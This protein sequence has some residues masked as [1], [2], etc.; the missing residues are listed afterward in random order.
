MTTI[1]NPSP[2]PTPTQISTE[3]KWEHVDWLVVNEGEAQQLLKALCYSSSLEKSQSQSPSDT[4]DAAL[5]SSLLLSQLA[6]QTS[7]K[8]V[9]IVCTLGAAGVVA[10][11]L[12]VTG[13]QVIYEPGIPA[14]NVVDTTGAG[15]CWTGYL[16]VGLMAIKP[17]TTLDKGHVHMLLRRC[18]QVPAV[19]HSS[20]ALFYSAFFRFFPLSFSLGT[21]NNVRLRRSSCL[22]GCSNVCGKARGDGKYSAMGRG[23]CMAFG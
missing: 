16:A 5:R 12:S 13:R 9:N 1:Y 18:N 10:S 17:H 6:S 8:N 2:M 20:Y 23:G 14:N 3:M 19:L 22:I 15:D 11:Y 7:F 21:R 4:P